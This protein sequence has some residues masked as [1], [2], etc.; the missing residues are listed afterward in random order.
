V[1]KG[2]TRIEP[3]PEAAFPLLRCLLFSAHQVPSK[4]GRASGTAAGEP[5]DVTALVPPR[6][7]GVVNNFTLVVA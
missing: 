5:K 6:V 1:I 4:K 7:L 2:V 3:P